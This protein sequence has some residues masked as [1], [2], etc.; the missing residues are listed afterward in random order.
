[1]GEIKRGILGGFSGKVGTVVG[2]TWKDVS[3]MR[4]LA[5]SVSNPRTPKQQTQRGKFAMSMTFLRAIIPYVRIGYHPYAKGRTAFNAAMS[6]ILRHAITGSAPQL[7][8]DY[9][10]VLVARGTLMPV[11]NASAALTGGKL[12]LTWKDNSKMGDALSTDQAMPLVYNKERGEAYYDLEAAT[13]ADGTVQLT[14]PD[15]WEDEALAVYLAFRSEDGSRVTNSSCLKDDAYEGNGSGGNA[16]GDD[17]PG[18]GSGGGLDEN[19]LG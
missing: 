6:Y 5:I 17:K 7:A 16:G 13:R 12:T 14:L 18:G 19:P 8:V 10:R 2:S 4:A 3:Y 11:F 1:M 15:G 9:E